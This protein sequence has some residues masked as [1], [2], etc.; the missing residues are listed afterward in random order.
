MHLGRWFINQKAELREEALSYCYGKP[1][2][3]QYSSSEAEVKKQ[4]FT[5]SFH[6]CQH[7][8][9]DAFIALQ[10]ILL[11]G[12]PKADKLAF[13]FTLL[14]NRQKCLIDFQML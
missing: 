6:V 3:E 2:K 11:R 13:Q 9:F 10:H 14:E 1:L 8:F 7:Y 4:L 5:S 12:I